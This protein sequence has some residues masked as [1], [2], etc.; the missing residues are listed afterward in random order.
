MHKLQLYSY[1][2]Y[3]YQLFTGILFMSHLNPV[4]NILKQA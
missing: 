3:I 2:T 4:Q 1:N